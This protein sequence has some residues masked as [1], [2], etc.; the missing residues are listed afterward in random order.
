MF[1][2]FLASYGAK[3]I[4]I[5][6]IINIISMLLVFF[7]CRCLMGPKISRVLVQQKWFLAMYKKHCWYWW[8]FFVSVFLHSV[9]AFYIFGNPL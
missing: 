3:F 7:S 2:E 8:I 5:L 6:G 4:W 1:N 9:L